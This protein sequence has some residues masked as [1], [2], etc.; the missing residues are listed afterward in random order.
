[1]KRT[2]LLL[3]IMLVALVIIA[4]NIKPAVKKTKA[5]NGS[6]ACTVMANPKKQCGKVAVAGCRQKCPNAMT[7]QRAQ[8][9][10]CMK[11]CKGSTCQMVCTECPNAA[12]CT[13]QCP[14]ASGQCKTVNCVKRNQR[15][16]K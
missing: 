2:T 13:K 10:E 1:M 4:G 11:E 16:K 8:H 9:T 3:T 15:T 12:T 6:V 7:C 14:N 5:C